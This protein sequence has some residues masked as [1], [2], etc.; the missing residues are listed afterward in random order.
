M[1]SMV[2]KQRRSPTHRLYTLPLGAAALLLI[3]ATCLAQVATP[4][5]YPRTVYTPVQPI[6]N[7]ATDSVM[8]WRRLSQN[9][10]A[11]FS[12]ISGFLARNRGWPGEDRLRKLAESDLG[13]LSYASPQAVAHFDRY[14]PLTNSGKVRY[15]LALLAAN[16]RDR[17]YAQ[18]RAAWAGGTLTTDEESRLLASFPGAI[19]PADHDARMD[20]LLWAG[21]TGLAGRQLNYVSPAARAVF[22]ARLSMRANYPDAASKMAS[23]DSIARNDP[24]YIVDKATWLRT[25]GQS[26]AARQWLAA[27][28]TLTRKPADLEEWY[29]TLLVNARGAETDRQYSTA[30]QIARQVH[31]AVPAGM[32]VRDQ[33]IG[34]RDDYTSLAWLGGY[35]AYFNMNQPANAVP[36]FKSYAEAARSPQT[37]SKGYYWAGR[38]AERA[39]DAA[40]RQTYLS[41]AA[42]DSD[43]YY[44]QLALERLGRPLPRTIAVPAIAPT[45]AERDAFLMSGIVRATQYLGQTG[46]WKDQTLFLRA[47]AANAKTRSD[48]LLAAELAPRIGRPDLGVMIGRSA[49]VNDLDETL[50]AYYPTMRVPGG[51]Q[52]S[53][54][55]IHAIT[56]QESQ[57]DRQ[58]V[59]HAGAR[60]LMQ[61]MPATAREVAGKLGRTADPSMLTVDTD[62]NVTLGASYFQQM[63]RYYGGSYPLALAAYNAGPGNVNKWLRTNGD[64]RAGADVLK[65]VEDIPLYETKNYVQRVL[66]N[67]VMY[68]T[69]RPGGATTAQN[70]LSFY[71]GKRAPG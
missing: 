11:G 50:P 34:V 43:Q 27:P 9:D 44:G 31:D 12:E 71:L 23:V 57:F 1:A 52:S 15:A 38:A 25:S 60:G 63:L 62:F 42:Q 18:A 68:D 7:P 13:L 30:Y 55:M 28:R 16:Q 26:L 69:I 48:H 49:G 19:S 70:P 36:L 14:P 17:A 46:Q 45:T 24:G 5:P 4:Q 22:D 29:E 67:A 47:I 54:T 53:W 61:L 40:N 58:A 64:P 51:Y 8:Q 21:Q 35:N 66:E 2:S 56:R 20:R 32:D 10:G 39:N 3:P 41:L 33:P 6:A 65:W 59:S 37:R